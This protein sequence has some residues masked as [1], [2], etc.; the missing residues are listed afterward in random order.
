MG[1]L[2]SA[3]G[4]GERASSLA[5]LKCFILSCDAWSLVPSW[6][7]T[8]PHWFETMLF[9]AHAVVTLPS[10]IVHIGDQTRSTA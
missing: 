8:L 3:S 5:P 4:P 10:H 1:L 6:S 7:P 2:G 9:P